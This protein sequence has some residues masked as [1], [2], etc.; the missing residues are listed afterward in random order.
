[1]IGIAFSEQR[2]DG[3][4][5]GRQQR[6]HSTSKAQR[7]AQRAARVPPSIARPRCLVHTHHIV[8]L[9][10]VLEA[11]LIKLLVGCKWVGREGECRGSE[12]GGRRALCLQC[13]RSRRSQPPLLP[14]R[15]PTGPFASPATQDSL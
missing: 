10:A 15:H 13:P 1:M 7:S 4:A 12:G 8:E 5:H 9:N 11:E 6:Q 14:R 2:A 3:F